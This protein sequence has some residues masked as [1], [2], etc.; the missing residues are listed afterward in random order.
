MSRATE[1]FEIQT[2]LA[3]GD[4]AL[5]YRAVDPT[6]RRVALKLLLREHQISHP[7]DVETLLRDAPL[8]QTIVGVNIVQLLDAFPDEDG[9]VLVYEYAE[10]HRGLDV[11]NRRPISAEHAVDVAAQLLAALRSGERQRYP[12][13][14]LKPSDTVIVDLP[15]G[16]PLVMVL[17]W[18]LANFRSEITPESFAYT[19]P[20]RLA[21]ERPSHS[22]DLFSAGA[23]LHYL[24]TGKRILPCATREE[25][26]AAWPSL[27]V[28][29]LAVLRPDL[30]K[31]LVAWVGKLI[32][33]DPA[34][35]PESAVKALE[36]LAA[37]QPPLPPAVP[38]NIRPK[39]VRQIPPPPPPVAPP[40]SAIQQPPRASA[41]QQSQPQQISADTAAAIAETKKDIARLAKKRQMLMLYSFYLLL[42]ASLGFGGF[43][44]WKSR[45]SEG[46]QVAEVAIADMPVRASV[47]PVASQKK[48]EVEKPEVKKP[49]PQ[50]T[51]TPSKAPAAAPP[52]PDD[53]PIFTAIEPLEY[54]QGSK[55]VGLAGGTGWDGPWRGDD[56][57]I[58]AGAILMKPS[59]TEAVLSRD[60]APG[61]FD[62]KKDT[63]IFYIAITVQHTDATPGGEAEFQFHALDPSG[64]KQPFRV[65][66][67][68]VGPDFEVSIKGEKPIVIKDDKKPLRLVQR[69]ELKKGNDGTWAVKT[70]L[71]VNPPVPATGPP[72]TAQIEAR[73]IPKFTLP[74]RVGLMLRKKPT[75]TT[76]VTGIQVSD[77]W[78]LLR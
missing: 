63:T 74:P 10:G 73:E 64:A 45:K 53:G 34:Q 13:G 37:L 30:P 62:P 17:D 65:V 70:R 26:A 69:L 75:P 15:D 22:A 28:S 4:A 60:Y 3:V 49:A 42:I 72:K 14:D 44:V 58:D 27:D 71:Y 29:T 40:V 23:T 68:K 41:I 57:E 9:T 12:H 67:G 25:F 50:K 8:I 31:A 20:E 51:T 6:G 7:L 66:I 33:P 19:A 52:K 47:A 5:V 54:P 11:P 16:R 46:A 59:A 78:K 1:L 38:E 55:L 2:R 35:R 77:R 76:R 61:L 48:P 39:V 21:G 32:A 24:Y 56:A 36:N 43:V 18:A